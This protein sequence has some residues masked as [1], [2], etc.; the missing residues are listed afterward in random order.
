MAQVN[1]PGTPTK[2][3]LL[4]GLVAGTVDAIIAVIPSCQSAAAVRNMKAAPPYRV[5]SFSERY[6]S[7]LVAPTG[8]AAV[9][10]AT[11]KLRLH[12]HSTFVR[13]LTFGRLQ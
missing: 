11:P 3:A 13:S 7:I 10:T 2:I 8:N 4:A 5:S 6:N 9:D 1:S 12:R